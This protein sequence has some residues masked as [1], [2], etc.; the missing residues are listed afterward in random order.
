MTVLARFIYEVKPGRTG[1]FL[2]K[3]AQAGSPRFTSP[4]MPRAFKLFR[5]SVPGPDTE[6]LILHIEYDD[7]AAYGARAAY[8]ASNPEW[9]ALFEATPDSPERLLSVELLTEFLPL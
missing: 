4:V 9:R 6:R 5:C 3:L 7:M 8:E 1:D 2:E